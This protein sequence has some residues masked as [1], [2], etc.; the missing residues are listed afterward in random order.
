MGQGRGGGKGN[1]AE[2]EGRE[3]GHRVWPLFGFSSVRILLNFN[4]LV[5][6]GLF[7]TASSVWFELDSIPV[8]STAVTPTL[9]LSFI[10]QLRLS[11][12][13]AE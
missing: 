8:S 2:G 5:R 6:F 9:T 10:A 12:R 4:V 13:I 11:S 3:G 7:M 1:E